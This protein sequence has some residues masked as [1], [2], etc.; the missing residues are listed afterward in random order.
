M[1]KI[2]IHDYET[3]EDGEEVRVVKENPYAYFPV[4]IETGEVD[5]DGAEQFEDGLHSLVLGW[6]WKKLFL[7]LTP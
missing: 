5:I 1:M 7:S 4:K 6:E 3:N 2:F